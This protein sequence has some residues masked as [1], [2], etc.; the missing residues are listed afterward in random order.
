MKSRITIDLDAFNRP[1]IQVEYSPSEDVRDKL[2]RRFLEGFAHESLWCRATVENV[3]ND[4]T[5]L[6]IRPLAPV[7]FLQNAKEM[8]PKESDNGSIELIIDGIK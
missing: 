6:T 1:I 3:R 8:I 5:L 4:G 2:V 7:E